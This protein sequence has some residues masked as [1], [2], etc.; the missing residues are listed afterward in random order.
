MGVVC[1]IQHHGGLS[2]QG[3]ESAR[4][5]DQSQ[6]IAHGLRR[7]GQALAQG[8]KQGQCTTGIEQLI[9][10]PQGWIGQS[11]VT[12]IT[13]YPV[14]LLAIATEM[15]ITPMQPQICT[16]GLGMGQHTGRGHGIA[17]DQGSTCTR[18]AHLL[19]PN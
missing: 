8:L 4:Q 6:A 19:V 1:H 7:H 9:R 11:V 5:L 13:P 15:K 18:N 3:L 17:D 14:P 16:N 2:R 10:T 12:P